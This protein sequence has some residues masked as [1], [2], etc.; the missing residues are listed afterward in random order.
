MLGES[1]GG[2]WMSQRKFKSNDLQMKNCFLNFD[3]YGKPISLTF[4]GQEKFRTPFGAAITIF[5]SLVLIG[6][7]AIRAIRATK[8]YNTVQVKMHARNLEERSDDSHE[9]DPTQLFAFGLGED[10][11]DKSIGSFKLKK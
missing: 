9:L 6:F 7:G 3:L 1:N 2:G 10:L 4:K 8:V 5:V 11:I